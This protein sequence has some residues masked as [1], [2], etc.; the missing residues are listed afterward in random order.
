MNMLP[1]NKRTE[2]FA[3]IEL[4][5]DKEKAIEEAKRCLWCDLAEGD[6]EHPLSHGWSCK[7]GRA[8][9]ARRYH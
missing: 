7:R 9:T 3:Q 4:G 6:T 1:V 8:H 5:F 2:G